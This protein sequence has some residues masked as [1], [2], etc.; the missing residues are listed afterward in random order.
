MVIFR[1]ISKLGGIQIDDLVKGPHEVKNR[2]K[3]V[4]YKLVRMKFVVKIRVANCRSLCTR[5]AP[6]A[7]RA[8]THLIVQEYEVHL[9]EDEGHSRGGRESQHDIVTLGV[10]FQ[11]KVL[12]EFQSRVDHRTDAESHGAHSQVKTTV[13]L[14]RTYRIHM[15]ISGLGG[16]AVTAGAA[17]R[18]R[19]VQ[20]AHVLLLFCIAELTVLAKRFCSTRRRTRRANLYPFLRLTLTSSSARHA[21]FFVKADST[22]L[23]RS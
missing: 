21:N 20:I 15:W 5:I 19:R 22:S 13:M 10:A 16:V 18:S 9:D 14:G 11:F 2:V 12:A 4:G 1:L 8:P 3:K 23:L 7:P 6:F 17:R